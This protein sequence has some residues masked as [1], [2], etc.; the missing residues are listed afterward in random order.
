MGTQEVTY[1]YS[2]NTFLVSD[3]WPQVK[4]GKPR[5]PG[6]PLGKNKHW[7]LFANVIWL[8]SAQQ[9]FWVYAIHKYMSTWGRF[10]A[11]EPGAC[12]AWEW[13]ADWLSMCWDGVCVRVCVGACGSSWARTHT[14]VTVN[15]CV[16]ERESRRV[17]GWREVFM[18][19]WMTGVCADKTSFSANICIPLCVKVCVI[20]RLY[21]FVWTWKPSSRGFCGALG[22]SRVNSSLTPIHY[23]PLLPPLWCTALRH[24]Q[25]PSFTHNVN[26]SGQTHRHRGEAE[27]VNL[28]VRN[29]TCVFVFFKC[30]CV[31]TCRGAARNS[32]PLG[33]TAA[34][35]KVQDWKWLCVG[36][37]LE[38]VRVWKGFFVH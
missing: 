36:V 20:V 18:W 34:V 28:L 26:H 4:C 10:T 19:K 37:R 9:L 32:G 8:W 29:T 11:S 1:K 15:M 27:S 14:P 31:F 13:E 30:E 23:R 38:L 2:Q 35:V 17:C 33:W 25:L 3:S 12:L 5:P 22:Q 6:S 16:S 7:E 24:S 21:I